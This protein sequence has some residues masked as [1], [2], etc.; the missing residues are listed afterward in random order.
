VTFAARTDQLSPGT[1][2]WQQ[3]AGALAAVRLNGPGP[4]AQLQNWSGT[5][6]V[7]RL[8]P[9]T[10]LSAGAGGTAEPSQAAPPPPNPGTTVTRH[11]WHLG[12]RGPRA[13]RHSPQA[14]AES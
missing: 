11:P 8:Q 1:E 13:A 10:V 5:C 12:G 7:L 2:E 14:D 6:R 4:A 3:A 9:L